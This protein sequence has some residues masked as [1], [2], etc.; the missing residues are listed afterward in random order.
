MFDPT[1]T[2]AQ[3]LQ[4]SFEKLTRAERQ[5]ANSIL[6]NYP[7]S[8]MGTITIVA[9]NADVSTPTVARM[10]QKL[11]YKAAHGSRTLTGRSMSLVAGSPA[12]LPIISI[13]TCR[14]RART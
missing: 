9:K 12:R 3:R 7:V 13:C 4:K 6:E 11:G 14:L 5:L 10:V 8:G 2:I 1:D